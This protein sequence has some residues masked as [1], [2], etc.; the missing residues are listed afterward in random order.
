MLEI[1]LATSNVGKLTEFRA[2][3]AELPITIIPQ[4]DFNVE[5]AEETGLTFIENAIIKARHAAQVTGRAALADDSGLVVDV[6]DGKPGIYSARFAG[7]TANSAQNIEKLLT[8]MRG[9]EPARRTA[10]FV[11]VLVLMR[12]AQDPSP[13]ISQATWEGEILLSPQGENGFG[14]DPVFWVP[15]QQCTAAQLPEAIKNQLSHRGQALEGVKSQIATFSNL[16]G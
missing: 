15:G 16:G 11:C 3:M 2:L 13:V 8:A 1:V 14:Y 4:V 9:V 12:H 5:D 10:R 6:L 7:A